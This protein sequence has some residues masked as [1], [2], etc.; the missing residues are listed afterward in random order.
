MPHPSAEGVE[1]R[2]ED[3]EFRELATCSGPLDPSTVEPQGG[4]PE[5]A[6]SQRER[7]RQHLGST[8]QCPEQASGA[9]TGQSSNQFS[10]PEHGRAFPSQRPSERPMISFMI[11]FVPP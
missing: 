2:G 4:M 3:G 10:S 5:V 11:S 1:P 9:H 6:D 8:E 7:L